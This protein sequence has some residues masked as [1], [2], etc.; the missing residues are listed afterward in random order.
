MYGVTYGKRDSK[1]SAEF[2]AAVGQKTDAEIA[3]L[4]GVSQPAVNRW[5]NGERS[6]DSDSR[7]KIEEVFGVPRRLWSELLGETE[8]PA[9]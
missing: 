2:R 3:A 9:A 5:R 6:P 1:G 8:N 7:D 4:L